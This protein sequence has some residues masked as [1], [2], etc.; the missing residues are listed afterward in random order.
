MKYN[1]N[2]FSV[3]EILVVIAVVGLI[4]AVSWLVYDRQST[5]NQSSTQDTTTE[6]AEEIDTSENSDSEK[7]E[8]ETIET[9]TITNN[10]FSVN[11]PSDWNHRLCFDHDGFGALVTG[12]DGGMKCIESDATWLDT[13]MAI[14]GKVAIGYNT[15]PF[16]RQDFSSGQQ[17]DV[18]ETDAEDLELSDGRIVKKYSYVSEQNKTAKTFKVTEYTLD[19][20]VTVF[21]FDGHSA[22]S[23]YI[24]DLPTETIIKMIEETVLPSIKLL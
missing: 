14:H 8:V 9:E 3:V 4:G 16:P 7:K 20:K 15:N 18:Y 21:V 17:K 6:Q 2:G 23:G 10:K 13:D 12:S 1:K 22:E 5:S 11:L 19:D 24:N